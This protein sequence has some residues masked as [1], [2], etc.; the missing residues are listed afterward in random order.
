[1]NLDSYL[2]HIQKFT[3]IN[4]LTVRAKTIKPLEEN[5]GGKLH[6]TEF[7]NDFM[8]LTPKKIDKLDYIKI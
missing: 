1:M 7:G 2:H 8:D 6:D 4:N 3:E 5:I